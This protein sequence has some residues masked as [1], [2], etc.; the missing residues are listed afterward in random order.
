MKMKDEYNSPI[1]RAFI[2][3]MENENC[4]KKTLR[5]VRLKIWM[6]KC[7]LLNL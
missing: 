4:L 7:Y 6:L 3:E 2:A 5:K 1:I